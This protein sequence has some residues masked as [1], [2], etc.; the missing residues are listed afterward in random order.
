MPCCVQA[1]LLL[2][3]A[4]DLILGICRGAL[5]AT[6]APDGVP[7]RAVRRACDTFAQLPRRELRVHKA[8]EALQRGLLPHIQAVVAAVEEEECLA[9]QVAKEEDGGIRKRLAAAL[10]LRACAHLGCTNLA[11]ASEGRLRVRRCGG[12][13]RVRFCSEECAAAAWAEHAPVC[14]RGA[15]TVC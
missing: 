3:P 10:E 6:S 5:A 9:G 14:S 4:R 2:E 11:G 13:G 7:A 1:I 12:C 8:W 15:L